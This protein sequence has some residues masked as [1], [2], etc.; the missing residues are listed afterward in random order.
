M[1]SCLPLV[2]IWQ[3]LETFLMFLTGKVCIVW[4]EKG[5]DVV[6]CHTINRAV[7]QRLFHCQRSM[8]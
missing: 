3:W 5:N 8:I 6:K 7:P 2:G 4:L 1:G